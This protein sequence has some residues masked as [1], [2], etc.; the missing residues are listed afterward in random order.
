MKIGVYRE[1]ISEGHLETSFLQKFP[2]SGSLHGFVPF[3]M[4][5][6]DTPAPGPPFSQQQPA[7]FN[8]DN[9]HPYGW[10]LVMHPAAGRTAPADPVIVR[11]ILQRLG[12]TW[13][14]VKSDNR[15]SLFS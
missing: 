15:A 12:T 6:G 14:V 3:H 7:G 10:V 1:Y 11:V 8:Q 9:R 5:T 4:P 2:G 13:A